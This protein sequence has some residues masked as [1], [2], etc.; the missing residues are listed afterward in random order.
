MTVLERLEQ[1]RTFR[2]GGL[3]RWKAARIAMFGAG[4]LGGFIATE[5][6]R[7]GASIR[8]WDPDVGHERNLAT[9]LAR[10]G[11]LKV[12]TICAHCEALRPGSAEGIPQDIRHAGPG[13]LAECDVLIDATDDASLAFALTETSNGLG[14]PLIRAAIDGSGQREYGRVLCSDG[15]N[16]RAC[17]ICSLTA[18][19]IW[20]MGRQRMTCSA[21]ERPPTLAGSATSLVVSGLAVLQAQR[22]VTGNDRHRVQNQELLIDLDSS[23]LLRMQLPATDSCLSGHAR[24][25][26]TRVSATSV[27]SWKDLFETA[28]ALLGSRE[29]VIEPYQHPLCLEAGCSCGRRQLAIGTIWSPAPECPHCAAPMRWYSESMRASLRREHAERLGILDRSPDATGMPER[30]ALY[31]AYAAGRASVRLLLSDGST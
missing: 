12:E 16:G 6:V 8:I 30:G 28:A 26:L 31:T 15:G 10:P 17:Q 2:D 27:Q 1:T 25:E 24:W 20:S 4:N 23:Q 5:C 21:P 13:M 29:V 18:D 19:E 9:Q 7:S 14:I 3:D 11:V 22:L